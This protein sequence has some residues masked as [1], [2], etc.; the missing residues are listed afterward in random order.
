MENVAPRRINNVTFGNVISAVAVVFIHSNSIWLF[1]RDSYWF[2]VNIIESVLYFA[3]PV[4]FMN[5]A[6]VNI[7]YREKYSTR[8]F[9]KKRFKKVFIPFVFWTLMGLL[10]NIANHFVEISDIDLPYIIRG[11][12]ESTIVYSFWFFWPLFT[13]YLSIPFVS[14]IP[15]EKRLPIFNYV[16]I[17]GLAF[18]VIPKF[19]SDVFE[20][21]YTFPISFPIG[22]EYILYIFIGYVIAH[23]DITLVKRLIIYAFGI[24]GL[25]LH[26]VG[27]YKLSMAADSVVGTFKGY[28]KLPCYLYAMGAFLLIK[29][30]SL[31]IKNEKFWKIMNK[32][33][34]YTFPVYLMHSFFLGMS[35]QLGLTL[36]DPFYRFG[37]PFIV[38]LICVVITE[39][40]R[41]VPVIRALLP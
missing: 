14:L 21:N 13:I 19:V 23:T 16:I 5:S 31:L 41:K 27:T 38:I 15:K 33:S 7:D 22:S 24:V 10:Y 29:Q 12:S 8:E 1:T 9:L 26:A 11:F 36:Q 3:V 4:F 32:A 39:N 2:S 37:V 20:L 40:V 34:G 25:L 6:I 28:D 18:S 35:T 30:V 17:L